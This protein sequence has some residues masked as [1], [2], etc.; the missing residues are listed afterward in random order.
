MATEKVPV[1]LTGG[2]GFEFDDCVAAR[3]LID[4]LQARCSLAAELGAISRI[5]WEARES[6]WLADD[7]VLFCGGGNLENAVGLSLKRNRQVNSA[8]FPQDFRALAWEQWDGKLGATAIKGT[9][10]GIGLVVGEL[11][12]DVEGA[13]SA[14]AQQVRETR[15]D[16]GRVLVRLQQPSDDDPGSQSSA[17]Q[18]ALV[19][20]L[21]RDPTG[22]PNAEVLDLISQT[23]LLHLDFHSAAARE[24]GIAMAECRALL[25]SNDSGEGQALWTF[26][27]GFAGRKRGTGGTIDLSGLLAELRP[28]FRLV[29]HPDFV[30]D[31]RALD[32]HSAESMSFISNQIAQLGAIERVDE[33]KR[34]KDCIARGGIAIF[35]GA[36]GTGKSGLAKTMAG[37][38]GHGVV[39]L[40]PEDLDFELP[41]HFES[42]IGLTHSLGRVL[43]AAPG[44][45]VVVFDAFEK[46]NARALR[47]AEQL[48]AGWTKKTMGH[49]AVLITTQPEAVGRIR[50]A[51]AATER[52]SDAALITLDLPQQPQ[53]DALTQK[54]S[55]L[56]R[57]SFNQGVRPILRNLKILDWV[58]RAIK[59]GALM[60]A[61]KIV[62]V[63]ALIDWLWEVAWIGGAAD[64]DNR[65][66]TLMDIGVKEGSSLNVGVPRATL[67]SGQQST[68][69]GLE[70]DGALFRRHERLFFQHDLLGDW[71]RLRVLM[72]E[73][74]LPSARWRDLVKNPRWHGALRLL[75][76]W[77]LETERTDVWEKLE[78]DCR[79]AGDVA[80]G[81]L[82]FE[83]I[84]VASDPAGR[85]R[86]LWPLLVADDGARLVALLE[87]FLYV[88]TVPDP[89]LREK[90]LTAQDVAAA[91]HAHR[92]PSGYQWL[93][94]LAELKAQSVM[95]ARIAPIQIARIA[96]L[97]LEHTPSQVREGTPFPGRIDAAELAIA[98]VE[99]LEEQRADGRFSWGPE[100]MSIFESLLRAAPDAPARVGELCLQVAQRRDWSDELQARRAAAKV[101]GEAR[102]KQQ[103]LDNPTLAA[104]RAKLLSPALP[105]GPLRD[106]WPDG[107]RRRV[108]E[109]FREAC[110]STSAFSLLVVTMP[111][112]ALEILLAVC[113]EEPRHEDPHNVTR[114]DVGLAYWEKG[115]PPLFYKGPFLQFLKLAPEHGLSFVL[116]LINFASKRQA[117]G[118]AILGGRRARRGEENEPHA[119]IE[120]DG[121]E[122]RWFG[123]ASCF[124]WH[125]WAACSDMVVCV[126]QALER[127][128]HEQLDGD[129]DPAPWL[130]RL[131]AE[132]R[133]LAFAGVLVDVGKSHVS[134]LSGVLRPL[135]TVPEFY[136]LDANAARRRQVENPSELIG[137]NGRASVLFNLAKEW[138][139]AEHRK[140]LLRDIAVDLCLRRED[141]GEFFEKLR[142]T[143]RSAA[144]G[145][146]ADA[147]LRL[148]AERFDPANYKSFRG[149]EGEVVP[150]LQWPADVQEAI[151]KSQRAPNARAVLTGTPMRCRSILDS[152]GPLLDADRDALWGII[153]VAGRLERETVENGGESFITTMDATCAGIAV[154]L[155]RCPGWLAEDPARLAWC[156]KQ[157]QLTIDSPTGIGAWAEVGLD[158]LNWPSFAA[159]CGVILL[160]Q[161]P[162]DFLARELVGHAAT[163]IQYAATAVV[164]KRAARARAVLGDDFARLLN[165]EFEWCALRYQADFRRMADGSN[166]TRDAFRLDLVARFAKKQLPTDV[167]SLLDRNGRNRA[168]LHAATRGAETSLEIALDVRVLQAA[169][170][171]LDLAAASTP[172]ERE[173]WRQIMVQ[174]LELSLERVPAVEGGPERRNSRGPQEF[175]HWVLRIVAENLGGIG[176]RDRERA[177]WQRVIGLGTPGYQWVDA[178]CRA[179]VANGARS[180][181]PRSWFTEVW[182]AMIDAALLSERWSSRF[183]PAYDVAR[184]VIPLL[185]FGRD[186]WRLFN[187][188]EGLKVWV[189]MAP[190]IE[191]AQRR[192]FAAAPVVQAFASFAVSVGHEAISLVGIRWVHA[193]VTAQDFRGDQ[194]LDT[195]VTEF[196][197]HCWQANRTSIQTDAEL[198]R[199]FQAL[200]A[201]VS[202][203]GH[204]AAA[205]LRD[206]VLDALK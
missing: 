96:G 49:V 65:S 78:A 180:D 125:Y 145:M 139:A 81:A 92:V 30:P 130:R 136:S 202:A 103:G 23:Y 67:D 108:D 52:G 107:P 190:A 179:W 189:S 149:H 10:N 102:R 25:A 147:P 141:M 7:L 131:L 28:H 80:A 115:Y 98:V 35:V 22:A 66:A 68:L 39:W 95:A 185:G 146:P 50:G 205:T 87:R 197:R 111:D 148:L 6:G 122:R 91:E 168:D 61:T 171:W 198:T 150:Q 79:G 206:Q 26:L 84:L 71:A 48:I 174:L 77:L 127:W 184:M 56:R 186:G 163:A 178:F 119:I 88:G 203:N 5:A 204:I 169:L 64:G 132:S 51:L 200:L 2:A 85:I 173:A 118:P 72:G 42:Y 195:S 93:P 162:D 104:A 27:R 53:L 12:A 151:D 94:I 199:M 157:L 120:V 86:R 129:R 57:V 113:I 82:L 114:E 62:N 38:F 138:Y 137:W 69:K 75:G 41:S 97:F 142:G 183:L 8:G 17:V 128:L 40:G 74:P 176:D 135:L 170:A 4:L 106:P 18:R 187:G 110:L 134:L 44:S 45:C 90:G 121:V 24:E 126:L 15:S 181:W 13:W 73:S 165:L 192:W 32:R 123:E 21:A 196:L 152:D 182:S 191:R 83:A 116:R 55:A 140:R 19:Q 105:Q 1:S 153:S 101:A 117:Q 167:P 193:A 59:S 43:S 36:S 177:L 60:D 37:E 20:S 11:A 58:V 172:A 46:L 156:R 3:F 31:W 164:M 166:A 70:R 188:A 194:D 29:G 14:I 89:R 144:R 109:S 16:L 124:E 158:E 33:T 133:S 47:L 100:N 76:V 155:A 154:L 112:V 99:E 143:W 63:S 201:C 175:D 34:A 54:D 160:A 159:E 9:S 161:D